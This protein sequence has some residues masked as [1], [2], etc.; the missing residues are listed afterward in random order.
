MGGLLSEQ[1]NI[2]VVASAATSTGAISAESRLTLTSAHA[3]RSASLAG[4][5]L[6]AARL[7][8]PPSWD[9]VRQQRLE[10]SGSFHVSCHGKRE[11]DGVCAPS[12]SWLGR[13]ADLEV[14]RLAG[15]PDEGCDAPVRG[16]HPCVSAV[17]VAGDHAEGE[18]VNRCLGIARIGNHIIK[19]GAPSR[20]RSCFAGQTSLGNVRNIAIRGLVS[21]SHEVDPVQ[22]QRVRVCRSRAEA[23]DHN[24]STLA[25]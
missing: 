12:S 22:E 3:A 16:V 9:Q 21:E 20:R 2:D 8:L 24:C 15:F 19:V 14:G 11:L 25:P 10:V 4:S 5:R 6:A 18:T 23:H 17:A 13:D 1:P 7:P